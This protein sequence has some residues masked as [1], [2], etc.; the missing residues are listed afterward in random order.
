MPGWAFFRELGL[1][2]VPEF[3]SVNDCA[4][5]R[6]Q[7]AT[8]SSVKGGLGDHRLDENVRRV[9]IARLPKAMTSPVNERLLGLT[10]DLRSHF[11]VVLDGCESP[12]FMMYRPGGFYQPH[13]DEDPDF[14][15][16]GVRETRKV[17][18]VVF[19]NGGTAQPEENSFG[20]GSLTFYG[21]LEG[22]QWGKCALALNPEPGLLVAFPSRTVHQV[23]PVTFGERF[24]IV[25]WF[26][27]L[28]TGFQEGNRQ[29]RS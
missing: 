25:T 9:E 17:S 27:A 14:P 6:R 1:Y 28:D 12:G 13:T 24:V 29:P 26:Y 21:L 16:T 19:L 10:S 8:A 7:M 20:G 23:T 2:V 22:P 5:L 3:L 11:D 18:V 15:A 4:E